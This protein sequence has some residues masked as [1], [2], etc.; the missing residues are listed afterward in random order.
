[1]AR[2]SL[3]F[4]QPSGQAGL[5]DAVRRRRRPPQV[6]LLP[7]GLDEDLVGALVTGL[8]APSAQ[9][10]GVGLPELQAPAADGLVGDDD[11][12]LQDER[13]YLGS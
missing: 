9:G 2:R 12:A 7:A 3:R 6:L 13:L 10:V 4:G 8:R 11:A 5:P 1:M